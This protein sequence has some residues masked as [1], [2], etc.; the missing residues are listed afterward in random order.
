MTAFIVLC[1][2]L[3]ASAVIFRAAAGYLNVYLHKDPVPLRESFNTIPPVLGSWESLY[4]RPP[5]SAELVEELGTSDYF[6]RIYAKD[7]DPAEGWLNVHLAYYTGMIDAVPHIPDRCFVAGGYQMATRPENDALPLD[8]SGWQEVPGLVNEATGLPYLTCSYPHPI[9]P[10]RQ[11]TVHMPVGEF[12]LR[13]LEF[14]DDEKP[15]QR[16]YGGYFFIANGCT[17]PTPEGVK[18]LAF[19]RTDKYAYYCKVQFHTVDRDMTQQRFVELVADLLGPLLPQVMNRL[20][21]W[22]EWEGR[23][24]IAQTGSRTSS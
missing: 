3:V 2:T 23:G 22:P 5:M 17:T 1:V 16:I 11:I 20:P 10:G 19:R 6:D 18:R 14:S 15:D 9:M 21:D 7:G 12:Q 8:T 4:E 13:T 24:G